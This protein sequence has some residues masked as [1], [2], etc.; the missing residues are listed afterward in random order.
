MNNLSERSIKI[1]ASMGLILTTMIWGFAFVVMKNSVDVIPPT[2][3][4]AI[5]FSMSAVLL[6]LLFHKNMMKADRE[7]VLCGVILGAFL[8]LSYQFQTYGLKHTTA[9]K[10]AFITTLY[11]IIVPFL[12]WI[13]SKKR[14]TGRNIAAAFLAVIGLALLSL[15]GDLSINYGDF[16][17]LVCGLM[18]AVHM[19]FIDKFTECHDPIALTVIQILAAA[20]F[21]WICAPFLDGSFDFTVLMD[22]S[23][24]GG[25]LYLAVF[26]TTVAYLLQNSG[27]KYLSAS[28]SVASMFAALFSVTFLKYVLTGK[29]FVGC[30]LMF[31][32]VL[33]SE[34]PQKKK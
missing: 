1:L 26:S 30:A 11:V 34:L 28:R 14:P 32:A 4:L 27:Q 2:Y 13:V 3:L 19:V 8:C 16:L 25:L 10:N 23:L 22:K 5:R 24:I 7:T 20:I 15:Q 12:Y 6:A 18:F 17:T 33:L 29:I 31:A 9:S 21:N